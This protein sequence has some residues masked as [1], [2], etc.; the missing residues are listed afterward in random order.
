VE[1]PKINL[2]FLRTVPLNQ[3]VAVL[4]MVLVGISAI[5]YTYVTVP[6][7][8]EITNLQGQVGKLNAE[9]ESLSLKVKHLDQLIAAGKQLEIELEKKKE[10]LPPMEE[11]F[12]LLKHLSDL[13]VR[14]GLD[15][16]SWRPKPH[17]EDST[18]L[19]VR[20]PVDVE[21][22]GGYHTAAMFFDRISKMPRI[23]NVSDVRMGS[24]RIEADRTVIQAVF[25]LT[26]F[27]APTEN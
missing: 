20:V 15:I 14:L 21:V 19:F 25:E 13:G 24:P 6:K 17:V 8:D 23:V 5:F 4:A 1:T 22:T 18:K 11:A 9:I 2:D 26:A 12:T 3:K 16:K 10:R 7:T 27:V